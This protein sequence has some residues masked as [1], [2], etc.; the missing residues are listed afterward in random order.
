MPKSRRTN[1]KKGVRRMEESTERII[2]IWHPVQT[3][4][5]RW[6]IECP[7]C[8]TIVLPDYS[9][10]FPVPGACPGCGMAMIP[11]SRTELYI[12][13]MEYIR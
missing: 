3:E 10:E 5:G 1:T 7:Q 12:G 6:A 13:K 11:D 2:P 8:K 9:Q 4:D